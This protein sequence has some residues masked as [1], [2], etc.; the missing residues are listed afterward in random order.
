MS[1]TLPVFQVEMWPYF[2]SAAVASES[3]S[4]T[5]MRMLLSVMT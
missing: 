3:H 5:A 4:L 1:V 2:A